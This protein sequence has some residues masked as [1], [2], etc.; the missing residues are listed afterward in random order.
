MAALGAVVLWMVTMVGGAA[1]ADGEDRAAAVESLL[2]KG[3]PEKAL[4]S[5][6]VALEFEP[7]SV[8]LFELAARA[9]QAAGKPDL[10]IWYTYHALDRLGTDE[11]SLEAAT[12]LKVRLE[13]LD[14]H[15]SR[16]AELQ[17]A[18]AASIFDTCAKIQRKKLYANAVD[19]LGQ[20]A[21]TSLANR[22]N[23]QLDK[24]F[25][26]KRSAEAI[27][28]SG[29]DVPIRENEDE[30]REMSFRDKRHSEWENAWE[31]KGKNYTVIT[32]M[33]YRMGKTV[34]DILE[35]MNR[36]YTKTFDQRSKQRS[37]VKIH[38]SQEEFMKV[39]RM[40]PFVGGFFMPGDKSVTTFDPRPS[41]RPLSRLW[42]VLFHEASHQFADATA[43][44]EIPAWLNEGTAAYFEGTRIL[45]SGIVE[46]NLIA[47]HRLRPLPKMLK[48]N[49]PALK[50]VVSYFAPGSYPG[51]YYPVG[52]GLV[53]FLLNY[54][55]EDSER[56]YVPLYHKYMRT[57]RSGGKHDVMGRFEDYFIKKARVPG[58][59]N[60][61]EFRLHFRAWIDE[62][63][64][65]YS[66]PAD[67]AD[68]LIA[69]ARKQVE[70]KKYEYAIE[71]YQWAMRK[72]PG[73]ALAAFE[74]AAVYEK[75]RRE[76][77]AIF[78]YRQTLESARA[79]LDPKAPM[80]GFDGK[81]AS[82][83]VD[84]CLARI[85]RLDP[86]ISKELGPA[87]AALATGAEALADE[88]F[89]AGR[90]FSA[91]RLLDD[92]AGM[93]GG[94]G[95]LA[96]KKKEIVA[97]SGIMLQ[98]WRRMLAGEKNSRWDYPRALWKATDDGGLE[99]RLKGGAAVAMYEAELPAD[100]RFEVTVE[101]GEVGGKG[102]IGI[103]LGVDIS[104]NKLVVLSL[105]DGDFYEAD[106][107]SEDEWRTRKESISKVAEEALGEFRLVVEVRET[108]EVEFF[109]DGE[110]IGKR[111]YAPEILEGKGLG[112]L[113]GSI[114]GLTFKDMR[115]RY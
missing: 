60:F 33:P 5:A 103:Y 53:Y 47:P 104:S 70:N 72:R 51:S 114:G 85:N 71:S 38:K 54:E 8:A 27:L 12:V 75:L 21:G 93:L 41:G 25:E 1:R 29:I 58:V 67:R 62:L 63:D 24:L 2:A 98:R 42:V 28:E 90:P 50:D 40:S 7:E 76:D 6:I 43:A 87:D 64:D 49:Q 59:T 108:G 26:N 82:E 48:A 101:N 3:E 19:L 97:K 111:Q 102:R 32:N 46:T 112:L 100:Y 77:A 66:G 52:W 17:E 61:E 45:P 36:F 23:E 18:Y 31:I 34:L 30:L 95:A 81:T 96:R 55:N 9:A 80:S 13:Q 22:A 91:V 10:A 89:K 110:S 86:V 11:A 68:K 14:P 94:H 65:L 73:D 15:V 44:G 92:A 69:R 56:I 113:G 105:D 107:E 57:Y 88:Y 78:S 16:A 99:T 115:I 106:P 74:L 37:V 39:H 83:V 79:E 4:S 109:I 35:Q 20:L 84:L